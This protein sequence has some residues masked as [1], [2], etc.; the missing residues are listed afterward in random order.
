MWSR[1]LEIFNPYEAIKAG[2]ENGV[3]DKENLT[4]WEKIFRI[5]YAHNG[6]GIYKEVY[7]FNKRVY[8][9]LVCRYIYQ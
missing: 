4:F 8:C 7:L 6:F 9:S 1:T 5:S 2:I 3:Y